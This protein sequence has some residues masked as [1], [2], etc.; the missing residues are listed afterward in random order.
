VTVDDGIKPFLH[1]K[2]RAASALD[3]AILPALTEEQN[4]ECVPRRH[5]LLLSP[6]SAILV[7]R[8][9][10]FTPLSVRVALRLVMN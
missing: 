3:A 1:A 2:N 4:K 9:S 8:S 5:G 6:A 10:D 7:L